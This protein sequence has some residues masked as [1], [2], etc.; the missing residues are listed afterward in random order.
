MSAGVVS[1]PL[2][3]KGQI[4]HSLTNIWKAFVRRLGVVVDDDPAVTRRDDE[5]G[6]FGN[7][8]SS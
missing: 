8:V 5:S 7:G 4:V 2:T 1:S 3:F 6:H